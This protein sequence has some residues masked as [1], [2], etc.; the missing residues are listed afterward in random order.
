MGDWDIG[1]T[2]SGRTHGGRCAS[3]KIQAGNWKVRWNNAAIMR[4][5]EMP[6]YN[7]IPAGVGLHASTGSETEALV[8]EDN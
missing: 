8:L 2:T 4:K 6:I 5:G 3:A 7:N 1:T